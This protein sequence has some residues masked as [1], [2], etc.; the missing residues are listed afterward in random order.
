MLS[1]SGSSIKPAPGSKSKRYKVSIINRWGIKDTLTGRHH[2]VLALLTEGKSNPEIAQELCIERRTVRNHVSE[3]FG[4]LGV[5]N[6]V[7]AAVFALR[8]GIVE[9]QEDRADHP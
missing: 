6:R 9:M 2:E 7:Q 3:I 5:D 1:E 8:T 4:R